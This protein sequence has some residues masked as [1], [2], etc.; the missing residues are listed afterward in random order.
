MTALSDPCATGRCNDCRGDA[1]LPVADDDGQEH[2]M[3]HQTI[4]VHTQAELDAALAA[5]GN[6][7]QTAILITSPAEAW[8]KITSPTA[9]AV[10]AV[11][12]A[13]VRASGS[14]TVEVWL[15]GRGTR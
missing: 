9:A 10:W 13:T 8:F 12:A 3:T 7:R 6:D 14:S 15:K 2:P 11:G 4:T 1:C 5:H